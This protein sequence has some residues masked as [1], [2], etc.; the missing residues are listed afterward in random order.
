MA[1]NITTP[2]PTRIVIVDKEGKPTPALVR[3]LAE[4]EKIIKNLMDR[5]IVLEGP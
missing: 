1:N 4:Q 2:I 3:Y 5:I